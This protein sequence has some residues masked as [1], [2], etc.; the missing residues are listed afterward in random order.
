MLEKS[1]QKI[2]NALFWHT[3]NRDDLKT[4]KNLSKDL[5]I[6]LLLCVRSESAAHCLF[7]RLSW[8]FNSA[9]FFDTQKATRRS[10]SWDWSPSRSLRKQAWRQ[11]ATG[12]VRPESSRS[13]S[14]FWDI[15]LRDLLQDIKRDQVV[16]H[17]S[18]SVRRRFWPGLLRNSFD[19][20][21]FHNLL[22]KNI[23]G[24]LWES[25]GGK[26]WD[27]SRTAIKSLCAGAYMTLVAA[28]NR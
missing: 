1:V 14:N 12:F 3:I 15:F 25:I 17:G 22:S 24:L 2:M 7:L 11:R 4:T 5:K 8:T 10:E 21:R 13:E 19:N 23:A 20:T 6:F 18:N 16:S 28:T 26:A 27:N 9:P